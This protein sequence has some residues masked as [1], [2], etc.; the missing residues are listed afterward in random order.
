MIRAISQEGDWRGALFDRSMALLE[1]VGRHRR[2]P[3]V[4]GRG[5]DRRRSPEHVGVARD[6]QWLDAA[7]AF[8]PD[9]HRRF[10]QG[11]T[12]FRRAD[13]DCQRLAGG[14]GIDHAWRVSGLAAAGACS[15]RHLGRKSVRAA[16]GRRRS[17]RRLSPRRSFAQWHQLV[18]GTADPWGPADLAAARLIGDTVSGRGYRNSAR[19]GSL[20]AED[21]LDQVR[22]Q[23]EQLRPIRWSLPTPTA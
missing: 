18:E 12:A 5:A 23:V 7:A 8:R 4:R 19:Y 21:Q 16:S 11:R 22:R 15:H 6:R 3:A 9:R 13:T 20:I 10:W 14:S 1:P 2:G 17:V